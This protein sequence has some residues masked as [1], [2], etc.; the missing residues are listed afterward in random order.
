MEPQSPDERITFKI[1]VVG[2]QLSYAISMDDKLMLQPS[3]FEFEFLDQAPFAGARRVELISEKMVDETWKP[4]WGKTDHVRDFY[5]EY[6][7]RITEADQGGTSRYLE[8][9]IRMYNDGVAFRYRFPENSGFGE[10]V[11]T[12][13]KT[14]F[15]LDP[16]STV[17]AVN[18]EGYYTHQESTFDK[19]QVSEIHEW[20]LIGCPLL[21]EVDADHWMALSEADLT[22]W[23]GMYFIRD[24]ETSGG[25]VSNLASLKRRSGVKVET[26]APCVSPWRMFM[27]GNSPGDLIESNLMVN[28]NDPVEYEDTDW[29]KPGMSAWDRW[30]SGDYGPDAG[31]ELNMN[32]ATMK[33]FIDLADEMDWE[34]MIVDWTWYGPVFLETEEG[35]IP[36]PDVDITQPI[37]EVDMEEIMRYAGERDVNVILWVLS[38]HLDRQLEEGLARFAEWGAA[39]VKIDFMANDDQDMVNWYHKVARE[40]ARHELVIDF[41]GAYKPTGVSRTLPNMLTREGVLG[42]EYNKWSD[43][44]KL[45]HTV[46]LPYTRGL[47]GEM[48][49]T[50]G[51]FNHVHE[52]DF[53]IVGGDAPNP[54]VMGT[55]CHQLAMFVVYESVFGVACDSPYNYKDQPG[56]DFLRRVPTTWS[57]TRFVSGYPGES[58][59]LARR[60]ENQWYLAGMTNEDARQ[61]E[62]NLDFLPEGRH[63][64]T[65]WKDAPDTDQN[66]SNLEKE[67]WE[68]EAGSTLTIRMNNGGG[69]VMVI[70][71]GGTVIGER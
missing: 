35:E 40:A 21:V 37:G 34:Y 68:V 63:R 36:H 16:S 62:V 60:S 17:W 65:L 9:V 5:N 42:N 43:F 11:I 44:I 53:K 50:P 54:Y 26:R 31:F 57:E 1:E 4:L 30:W 67:Q 24:G 47:L 59:V 71:E 25:L 18:Y 49:F 41:H 15:T 58:I 33:Y 3:S 51:G 6:V 45:R 7:Y 12:E 52:A 19:K 69:F 2:Q 14:G 32:T 64:V 61:V 29:I 39:G 20:E 27:L 46:T 13:E 8:W 28:L 55:R 48:D 70:G 23:A 22:D 10:F 38:A 56:T 66:P